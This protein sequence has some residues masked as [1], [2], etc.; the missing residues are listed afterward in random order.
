LRVL[1]HL[2]NVDQKKNDKS[3][4]WGRKREREERETGAKRGEERRGRKAG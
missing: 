3:I 2:F 4:K 1:S